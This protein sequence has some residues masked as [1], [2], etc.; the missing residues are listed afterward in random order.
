[1]IGHRD[2]GDLSA[3]ERRAELVQL[4][5]VAYERHVSRRRGE[6]RLEALD[7]PGEVEAQCPP[8][9]TTPTTAEGARP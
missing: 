6:N 1:M 8:T 9:M 3:A 4:L 2:P 7:E 5:A